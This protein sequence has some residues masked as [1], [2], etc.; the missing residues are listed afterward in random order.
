MKVSKFIKVHKDVLL[1]YVY[2]DNN[3]I[4]DPYKILINSKDNNYSYVASDSS[5]TKNIDSNQL[6]K[7][8]SVSN[9]YGLLNTD[10]YSFLQF[11]E[12]SAGFPLR[13]DTIRIHLPVNYT[14]GEYLGCYI[15]VYSYDINNKI[16]YDLSN[17][18]FDVTDID[19]SYLLNYT[20]PPILFQEKLWGKNISF[21]IPSLFAVSA[22]RQNGSTKTNTVNYNLTNGSGMS[23]NSPIFVEFSFITSKKTI[24]GVTTYILGQK[25]PMSLPQTPDF[26]KLGVMIEHSQNGDYF[27]I[28]GTF[29]GNI[30][31]FNSFINNSVQLG[32]RY[33]VKYQI[34]LFEQN[35]RG[36]TLTITVTDSFNEKIEYRPII[37]YSSTTAIIDIE[38]SLIDAVDDSIILRRASYGMLQDE[39][40]KY[41]LNLTKINIANANKPKIYNIK[42]LTPSPQNGLNQAN[43]NVVLEPVKVNYTVLA[44]RFNVVAKS[45]NVSVGGKQFYGIGKLR[46]SLTPFDNVIKLIIASDVSA[47]QTAIDSGNG[48]NLQPQ[49]PNYMDLSNMGEIKL[50]IK[51]QQLS[52]ECKLY[53]ASNEVDLG[54]GVVV[55]KVLSSRMGD[56]RK[57]YESGVNVFYV[58]S[59]LDSG[60][61][62]IY[63]GLFVIYDSTA[64]ITK[65][66]ASV[67]TLQSS[68]LNNSQPQIINDPNSKDMSNNQNA[69][70]GSTQSTTGQVNTTSS[71]QATSIGDYIYSIDEM[72]NLLIGTEKYTPSQLKAVLSLNF[73]PTNLSFKN[74]NLYTGD[75][76]LDK[77]PSLRSKLVKYT[78]LKSSI[79]NPNDSNSAAAGG[80]RL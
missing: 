46:L 75:K 9:T 50:V 1:E 14:F 22:Q 47:D 20:S 36:K 27:E 38:M 77:L 13:H 55:F 53:M 78:T 29:N 35:I 15:K 62:V 73:T 64:N 60:S 48:V 66:N 80:F 8:D 58:T 4:G 71:P 72:S 24:N 70:L 63:S 59:N 32:N 40:A 68:L 52:V 57:I 2:D 49:K 21:D 42:S 18:F 10:T 3:N 56:V 45:D 16:T 6:F 39:V 61:N 74:D 26:E 76:F 23:L 37:K 30:S 33:Y 17:F 54:N 19:T 7:I 12:Y 44:D 31:E 43:T 51:N 25:I 69:N 65:L 41:S 5:V 67:D 28:Y 11:K 79:S 34:T